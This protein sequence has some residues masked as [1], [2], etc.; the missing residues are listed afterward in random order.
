LFTTTRDWT[1]SRMIGKLISV[2]CNSR[3]S[4]MFSRHKLWTGSNFHERAVFARL[5][6]KIQST[7]ITS[8]ATLVLVWPE[9]E[10]WGNSHA[11]TLAC[12]LSSTLILSF[13]ES[14]I[15]KPPKTCAGINNKNLS[16]SRRCVR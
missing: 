9:H 2:A 8:H 5:T 1:R 16:L 3:V 12:Q 10:N 15:H 13:D 11:E 4:L 7:L 6:G 14:V